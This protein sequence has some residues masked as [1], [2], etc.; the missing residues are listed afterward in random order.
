MR[1]YALMAAGLVALA[2]CQK[3]EQASGAA[4]DT[5]FAVRDSFRT[6]ESVLYDAPDDVYLVSNIHGNPSAKD[7]NGFISKVS[8]DGRVIALKFIEGGK[9]GV[10]LHAPKGMGI[11]GDTLFVADIDELRMFSRTT[12]A[13]LGSHPVPG[14]TFLNDVDVGPDGAVYFSD[15]G[16]K[17]DFSASGT[18]AVYRLDRTGMH[19]LA[20]GNDL[21][22][23]NG[24]LG[25]STGVTVVGYAPT[26]TVYHLD[27]QGRRTNLPGPPAG[28]LD[29]VVRLND[30]TLVISSW[31]DSSIFGMKPGASMYMLMAHGIE[32]PADIG[33]DTR[34]HRLL[35]PVFNQNYI[36]IRPIAPPA[37]GHAQ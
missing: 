1:R 10:T 18:D 21:A 22:R 16:L 13:P 2:A 3:Q 8:P 15:S 31:A 19:K 30:G 28:A 20:H 7:D 29:G 32:S 36:Q 14:A 5:A 6:P 33:L 27:L 26:P 24:V 23:P 34:R 35:V 17:P 4:A 9:N 12:G 37:T 11:H 25:D